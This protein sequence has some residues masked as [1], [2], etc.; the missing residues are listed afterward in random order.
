[1]NIL[2]KYMSA[3]MAVAIFASLPSC[4]DDFDA[5]GSEIIPVATMEANTTIAEFKDMVWSDE[6]NYCE[7]VYTKQYYAAD[8]ANRTEE[9][10]EQGDHII[11]KGRVVS[12]DYAGNC[13]KYIVL[14]DE[15]GCINFS[16]NSYNLYLKYR[17]GQEIVV[18]LTGLSAGKYRGL[19]QLGAPSYNSSIPG[20][21]TSFM[22]P[23]FFTRAS[24]LNGMPDVAKVDTVV[25]E[26]FS[27]LGVTP[28]ELRK[29]QSTL[30]RFNNVEFVANASLPTLSTYHSSGE[31]QQIRDAEGNTLD[32]RTSGYANFWN[33]ELP[34][35]KCDVVA[36]LGYYVN[37]AG[38]GGWQL[39][40]IDANSIMNVGHPSVPKGSQSNPYDVMEAIAYQVNGGD[41]TGWVRGYIVGT[42]APEV[43]TVSSSADIEWSAEATLRNTIVIGATP[44][45]KD[46]AQ[47]L[48]ITVPQGS[49]LQ[50]DATLRNNP[51]NYKKRIDIR[52]RF[53]EVM[54]TYGITGNNGSSSEFVVEGKGPQPPVQGDGTEA[55]PY[56]AAQVIALNPQSTTE[57]VQTGVWVRGYIV[58]YYQDY[59]GHFEAGGTQRA[60]IL[61]SDDPSTTNTS[62]CV[63]IQLVAQTDPRNALNLVDNPGLLGSQVSVHGDVMKYNTLPGI[64]N[65]DAYKLDGSTPT[66]TPGQ[67]L[68]L[69]PGRENSDMSAWTYD[70]VTVPEGMQYP[71]W[72]YRNYNDQT[73]YLAA[74]A[75]F[76]GA[77]HAS[78]AWAI[79]PVIDLSATKTAS[80]SFD[81]AARFQTTLR[82]LCGFA[83]REAG[84]TT[85]QMLPVATW[86]EAGSWTYVNSGSF[87]LNAY[88]GKKIQVAF[89]YASDA[90][91]ADTW[92]INNLAFDGD[93]DITLGDSPVTPPGPSVSYKG[94][95]DSFNGGT[96][97]S[98]YG[99][100]TNATGWTATNCAILGGQ[101]AGA[102]DVNPRFTFIGSEGTLAPT[103]TG[104]SSAPGELLSPVLTGGCKTLTF[105]YGF[106]FNDK[107]C[108]FTIE[109]LQND[110]VILEKKVELSN[111]TQ[112]TKYDYSLDVNV[113]GD[114]RIRIVNNSASNRDANCDRISIW[115]LTWTN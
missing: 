57:A 76:S 108:N 75:Y 95:F 110:A 12:S 113:T 90:S 89:K 30:V 109:I 8:P 50:N 34:A 16:I 61:I 26:K 22:S 91:G 104:K 94:D 10:K 46:I 13:F 29:W 47:C 11:V 2:K 48:V 40:L 85:W 7:T 78:E 18:D 20:Y 53:A 65:T 28:A 114:F 59:A 58:G 6:N 81:H 17:R 9:M 24:E 4:Q 73:F 92:Q 82:T 15:T 41:V 74:S 49:A 100:Y 32:I 45:T 83:V 36:L 64:K 67:K 38:T 33:M 87:N 99:S 35:E 105:N 93:G 72:A 3:L 56:T 37:L 54:G 101:A 98:S 14:Q 63:C 84:T 62:N 68:V 115:N 69:I 39:T 96:P 88:A 77:A 106:A 102:S 79:S 31:T 111:F 112:K 97:R 107:V 1:M 42:V 25:V 80:V 86:P 23:E 5:P 55:N 71:V 43:E 27:D 52:G 21:E 19:L 66:P 70:N 51:D 44:D 60:N 103:L